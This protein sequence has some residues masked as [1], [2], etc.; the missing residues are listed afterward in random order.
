M[1][2]VSEQLGPS[3]VVFILQRDCGRGS[4]QVV[5]FKQRAQPC[6]DVLQRLEHMDPGRDAEKESLGPEAAWLAHQSAAHGK[7]CASLALSLALHGWPAR[8]SSN[9][10]Y[11]R[12]QCRWCPRTQLV[13]QLCAS[14]L[15]HQQPVSFGTWGVALYTLV[16]EAFG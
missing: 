12:V 13:I 1:S 10:M 15:A 8:R 9:C 5:L 3:L 16:S 14:R 2:H 7:P 4:F 11:S 6:A